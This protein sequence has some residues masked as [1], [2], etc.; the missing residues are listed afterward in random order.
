MKHLQFWVYPHTYLT[1]VK[2]Y[3]HEHSHSH[4]HTY[5]REISESTD[6][7]RVSN[8]KSVISVRVRHDYPLPTVHP[9]HRAYT[10]SLAL[11]CCLFVAENFL[12]C[13]CIFLVSV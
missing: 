11:H 13:C 3:T 9:R 5:A 8:C 2:P 7:V 12:C 1:N 10:P 4:V 6:S